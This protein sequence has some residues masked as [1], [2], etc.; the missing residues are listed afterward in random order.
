MRNWLVIYTNKETLETHE[1]NIEADDLYT[2]I[3][4]AHEE[5]CIVSEECLPSTVVLVEEE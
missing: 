3:E 4:L 1:K 5:E 2:A